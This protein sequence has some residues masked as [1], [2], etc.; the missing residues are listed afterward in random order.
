MFKVWYELRVHRW[1]DPPMCPRVIV[2]IPG[3]LR[4]MNRLEDEVWKMKIY[5]ADMERPRNSIHAMSSSSSSAR[6]NRQTVVRPET[7]IDETPKCGSASTTM[8]QVAEL[9]F[10]L[11]KKNTEAK[12]LEN[13]LAEPTDEKKPLGAVCKCSDSDHGP[14]TESDIKLSYQTPRT[15]DRV[16]HHRQIL[17]LRFL[18]TDRVRG[19][20]SDRVRGLTSQRRYQTLGP[21]TESVVCSPSPSLNF[22][23][24]PLN[25]SFSTRYIPTVITNQGDGSFGSQIREMDA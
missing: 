6:Q 23:K 1:V 16:R 8:M 17:G 15:T 13:T 4:A 3:L 5:Y 14:R 7:G 19:K 21:R 20:T 9:E 24:Q 25:T 18:Y 12:K 22:S 2:V 11:F 10:L